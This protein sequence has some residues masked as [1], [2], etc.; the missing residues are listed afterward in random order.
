MLKQGF[1]GICK[2]LVTSERD[3]QLVVIVPA[4]L[5]MQS[6][7]RSGAL[8]AAAEA[9]ATGHAQLPKIKLGDAHTTS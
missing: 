5:C 2:L 9:T 3:S 6:I 8:E 1:N 4:C 7:T